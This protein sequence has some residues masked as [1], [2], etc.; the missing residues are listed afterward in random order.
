[1]LAIAPG[2]EL[3]I[4]R[5]PNCLLARIVRAGEF[6]E[7]PALADELWA[8]MKR[9]MTYQ[10]VLE[11]DEVG[12]LDSFLLGQ[13]VQLYKRVR[14]H[15]G[16]LRLCGL[17]EPDR[18]VLHLCQLEGLLPAYRGREDALMGRFTPTQ[19]R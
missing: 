2:W 1:M 4:E 8:Q 9:H 18:H 13:L 17:T 15:D 19:P 11:M 16:L 7:H 3:K 6:D 12:R 14:D 5:G 10:V